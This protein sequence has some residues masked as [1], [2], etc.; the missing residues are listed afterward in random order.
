MDGLNFNFAAVE[1]F[2]LEKFNGVDYF[3]LTAYFVDPGED[4]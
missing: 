2:Q 3:V 4:R 1:M